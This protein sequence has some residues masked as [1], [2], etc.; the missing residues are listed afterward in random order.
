MKCC[1][2]DHFVWSVRFVFVCQVKWILAWWWLP[3]LAIFL[4][5]FERMTEWWLVSMAS[6]CHI[7]VVL[8]HLDFLEST[9][10]RKCGCLFMRIYGSVFCLQAKLVRVCWKKKNEK[11]QHNKSIVSTQYLTYGL[12][13]LDDKELNFFLLC[14]WQ[15]PYMFWKLYNYCLVL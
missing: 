15:Y 3:K 11:S 8:S 4:I 1:I 12:V 6:S 13:K 14:M 10:S 2:A 9:T 7:R 5:W